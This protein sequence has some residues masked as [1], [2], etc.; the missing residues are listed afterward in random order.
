M[1]RIPAP[2]NGVRNAHR[3]RNQQRILRM[4]Q[5]IISTL[6]VAAL[7]LFAARAADLFRVSRF[8]RKPCDDTHSTGAAWRYKADAAQQESAWLRVHRHG[9]C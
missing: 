7:A 2:A 3:D 6:S 4:T 1:D 8:S 5:G 9:T